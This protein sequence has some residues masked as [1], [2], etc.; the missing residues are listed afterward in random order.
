[1]LMDDEKLN[2]EALYKVVCKLD[3]MI[4]AN[5]KLNQPNGGSWSSA[6][7]PSRANTQGN[8]NPINTQKSRSEA[9]QTTMVRIPK[10]EKDQRRKERLCIKCGKAGHVMKDC[11]G[12]WTYNKT[13]MQGKASTEK[14]SNEQGSESESEN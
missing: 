9:K 12:Q 2:L 6:W 5:Q 1:M 8:K 13:K 7:N 3:D 14:E 10:E 11:R 4:Y